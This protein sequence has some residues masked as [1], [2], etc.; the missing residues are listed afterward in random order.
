VNL[1]GT[2]G[3]KT[4]KIVMVLKCAAKNKRKIKKKCAFFAKPILDFGVTLKKMK[5]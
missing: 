3:V 4:K 1:N 2:F 5:H